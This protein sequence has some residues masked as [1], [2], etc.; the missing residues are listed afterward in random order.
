MFTD[1]TILTIATADALMHNDWDFAA[2]YREH[3]RKYPS[4]YGLRFEFIGRYDPSLV[5][6][7]RW[8]LVS[9]NGRESVRFTDYEWTGT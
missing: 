3:G 8:K 7:E 2:K 5:E 4:S 6:N 1:G 9:V